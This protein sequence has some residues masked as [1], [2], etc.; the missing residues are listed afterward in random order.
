MRRNVL[1]LYGKSTDELL[2]R[3]S[4]LGSY[5]FCLSTLL[6]QSN[7]KLWING[8]EFSML[9][10]TTMQSAGASINSSKLKKLIPKWVKTIKRD[11]A[12]FDFHNTLLNQLPKSIE[13]DV[14]FEFYTYGSQLGSILKQKWHKP[15]VLVFDSPVLEEY[16]FFYGKNTFAANKIR[17]RQNNALKLADR[18]VTYSD[19]VKQ[20]VSKIC[21]DNQKI[22]IHQN[23]DFTRFE[24]IQPRKADQI[25]NIGFIGSFLKWHRVDLL[26]D[27]FE[28]LNNSDTHLYLIGAGM[29]YHTILQKVKNSPLAQ[30]ITV[31]G[32]CDGETLLEYKKKLHIGVMSGSNW[33]GAPN[34]IFEYG[35]A[36]LTVL[37]PNTPTIADLFADGNDLLLFDWDNQQDCLMKLQNLI[38]NKNMRDQ[39]ALN[40]QVKI[41]KTYSADNTLL[42]YSQLLYFE[43]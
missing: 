40:L 22:F 30:Q 5:I 17:M 8:I 7:C 14:I 20:Y 42:F 13:F 18:I 23:V 19:P 12:I 25:I 34:K 24:F 39:L 1:L 36:G 15:Y 10:Q 35:A 29:E 27:V 11:R 9:Q 6:E 26:I 16:E 37:A 32:F 4:A 43:A 21:G 31:T 41:R 38:N 3:Q 2:N 33:Y 28:K